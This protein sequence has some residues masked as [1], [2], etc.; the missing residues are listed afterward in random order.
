MAIGL[1]LEPELPSS[2]QPEELLNALWTNE[3]RKRTWLNLFVW[4]RHA[5][6]LLLLNIANLLSAMALA[7]GRPMFTTQNECT[8][9]APIDCSIPLDWLKRVPVARS[10]SDKP[11]PMTERVLR[12][13]LSLRFY[14]IRELEGEGPIPRNPEKVKELHD[15]ALDFK[16]SLPAFY[17]TTNTDKRWDV[18][19][20]FV[21]TH[22]ELLSYLVD[23][24]LIALHR[25]YI[26]TREKSQIQVYESALA[27]LD[28]QDRLFENVRRKETPQLFI[29]LTFPTFDAAVLLAV[30]LVSSPERYHSIFSRPYQ[31]LQNALK[32]LKFIGPTLKL[33][34][35][36]AEI[37]QTAISR[38][39]EAQEQIGFC[40][41]DL[42]EG[43]KSDQ[44]PP[45][46]EPSCRSSNASQSV[47]PD[48]WQFDLD[49]PS[50][51]WI[52]QNPEFSDFDFSN[53]EVP[54]PLKE[55]LL[56]EDMAALSAGTYPYDSNL[57]M[58][59]PEQQGMENMAAGEQQMVDFSE[60]ELWNFL[61]GYPAMS[62]DQHLQ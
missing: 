62:E 46:Q 29:G 38:V 6:S 22:R 32:R 9:T 10:I 42:P 55:L 53:L 8:V 21:P 37:L 30:V 25:P 15:F 47:S 19:L 7:L 5:I 26:F 50:T 2:S 59:M 43:G 18:E 33:A 11:T 12:N 24:F 20:P 16:K 3:L 56:D 36:G 31:S 4:D 40:V 13:K 48:P 35:T 34:R 52:A 58:P 28:S 49:E 44:G 45:V 27:I 17:Q 14:E 61:T 41:Q 23:Q 57:W 1:H 39:V 60:N 51:D 54:M